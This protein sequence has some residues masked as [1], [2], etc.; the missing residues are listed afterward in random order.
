MNETAGF[1]MSIVIML[2]MFYLLVFIP[3]NRRK[4]KYNAMLNSLKLNDEIMTKGGIIGKITSIKEDCIL[5][6]TGPDRARIKMSKN[7]ISHVMS[8]SKLEAKKESKSK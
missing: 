7:G 8:E 1:I 3:E 4:K 5:L 6:Q 2:A